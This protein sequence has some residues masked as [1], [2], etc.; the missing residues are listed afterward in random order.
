MQCY[1]GK[2]K[3]PEGWLKWK[4]FYKHLFLL[5]SNYR[6]KLTGRTTSLAFWHV[7]PLPFLCFE[8]RLCLT[9][10]QY[11]EH[12]QQ[13]SPFTFD[14]S[15]IVYPEVSWRS[16]NWCCWNYRIQFYIQNSKG[17]RILKLPN[18]SVHQT[19]PNNPKFVEVWKRYKRW[20][21]VK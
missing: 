16:C 9:W 11:N 3:V 6:N 14:W 7:S 12:A 15:D 21:K 8:M 10:R 5:K 20:L 19:R 18:T 1:S 2:Q 4:V 17:G 13:W